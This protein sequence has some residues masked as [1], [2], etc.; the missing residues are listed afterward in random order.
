MAPPPENATVEPAVADQRPPLITATD[1]ECL[2]HY[3]RAGDQSAF[4]MVVD[5]HADMVWRV[6]WS[7]LNHTQDV[8]DAF[9]ATFLIL[10]NQAKSI[11]ANDSAAGWLYRVAHRTALARRRLRKRRKE[12]PL[13]SEPMVREEEAFPNLAARH[14]VRV[15]MEEL[16]GL[17]DH[18]QTPLVL[19]YLEGKS[20]RA[21][22]NQTDV[23]VAAVQGQLVRGK[24]LLRQRLAK[25]GVSLT[26]TMGAVGLAASSAQAETL[27]THL[28]ALVSHQ[29]ETL[30]T[31]GKLSAA[32]KLLTPAALSL[33]HQGIRTML[34]HTAIKPTVIAGALAMTLCVSVALVSG[35]SIA[36][37]PATGASGRHAIAGAGQASGGIT[38]DASPAAALVEEAADVPPT[39]ISIAEKPNITV[40]AQAITIERAEKGEPG[41]GNS[42]LPKLQASGNVQVV[43][44][45]NDKAAEKA[46]AIAREKS[47]EASDSAKEAAAQAAEARKQAQ[48]R[49]SQQSKDAKR[50]L[51]LQRE[52]WE[53]KAEALTS[54]AEAKQ[55]ER[56]ELK[57]MVDQGEIS[58]SGHADQMLNAEWLD[59]MAEAKL[60]EAKGLEVKLGLEAKP[61]QAAQKQ[62]AQLEKQLALAK[63]EQVKLLEQVKQLQNVLREQL[64]SNPNQAF[65]QPSPFG[66]PEFRPPPETLRD[67][68]DPLFND[69]FPNQPNLRLREKASQ[70][71]V[72]F[73]MPR[74]TRNPGQVIPAVAK[75]SKVAAE[76]AALKERKA[77]V[78][79]AI[80]LLNALI[81]PTNF[82]GGFGDQPSFSEKEQPVLKKLE[83]L[84]AE[85]RAITIREAELELEGTQAV[86]VPEQESKVDQPAVRPSGFGMGAGGYGGGGRPAN[87]NQNRRNPTYNAPPEYNAPRESPKRDQNRRSRGGFGGEFGGGYSDSVETSDETSKIQEPASNRINRSFDDYGRSFGGGNTYE[88]SEEK[89]EPNPAS[90]PNSIRQANQPLTGGYHLVYEDEANGDGTINAM[91]E[92]GDGKPDGKKSLG[93]RSHTIRYRMPTT[94][95]QLVGVRIHGSR[96]GSKQPPKEDFTVTLL[97]QDFKEIAVQKFPYSSF[98]RGDN[99]WV[100][101]L[102]D[103]ATE[104]ARQQ[105]FYI[106][107]DFDPG[108]TKGV[109]VSY[110]T[111]TRGAN[112]YIGSQSKRKL[113]EQKPAGDWMI[114]PILRWPVLQEADAIK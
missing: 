114:Q 109:Y 33:T 67:Y 49:E 101:L 10:A 23:T 70:L 3:R 40:T 31:A 11:R 13:D 65:Q 69:S 66:Q 17:P 47:R 2:M 80:A 84:R 87:A 54:K 98:K 93:G 52:Y 108:R 5:R 6:C 24:R 85:H 4:A 91:I 77:A 58:H 61:E 97:N 99:E 68:R 53:L 38:L 90:S 27:P 72:P 1:G 28:P 106:N 57:V 39:E 12:Q 35:D 89:A 62:F 34:L 41:T 78:K 16:R 110:D 32:T 88:T 102:L 74:Q 76:K 43:V 56:R 14:A 112:S 111:A 92:Y 50:A 21:I 94:G 100:T 45:A 113:Q 86:P 36:G 20:R 9:Q 22:A 75:V 19:R 37:D 8:E 51:Q 63:V 96:Y 60:A 104:P 95:K 29:A 18:Y 26:A 81:H 107:V 79:R 105:H 30:S 55:L 42:V 44:A 48:Q 73:G 15:L 82:G 25:R 83:K 103:K 71:N 7:V 64:S 46:K 59:L